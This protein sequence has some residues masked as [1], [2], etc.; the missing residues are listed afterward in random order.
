MDTL[1]FVKELQLMFHLS[2]KPLMECRSCTFV[3]LKQQEIETRPRANSINRILSRKR[4]NWIKTASQVKKLFFVMFGNFL[5][6]SSGIKSKN[7]RSLYLYRVFHLSSVSQIS[8]A[9]GLSSN[10]NWQLS[11]WKKYLLQCQITWNWPDQSKQIKFTPEKMS[12]CDQDNMYYI[13]LFP[14]GQKTLRLN[15]DG[16]FVLYLE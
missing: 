7:Q 9:N 14:R 3:L 4:A 15:E 6:K 2:T 11:I 10:L 5:T 12:Y 8:L 16:R 13:G 1:F